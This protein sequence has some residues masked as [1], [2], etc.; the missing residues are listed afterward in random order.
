[1][2]L[3]GLR[4][5]HPRHSQQKHLLRDKEREYT[6]RERQREKK[7]AEREWKKE[8]ELHADCLVGL[9]GLRRFYQIHSEQKHLLGDRVREINSE[10]ET[11]RKG[12]SESVWW[13]SGSSGSTS[14]T[15]TAL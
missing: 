7:G 3:L 1:M 13:V 15:S 4:R 2:G 9:L 14:L 5:Y 6:V 12:E 10:G 11:E 8:R